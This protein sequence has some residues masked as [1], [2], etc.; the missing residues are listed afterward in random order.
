[1]ESTDAGPVLA[2][3]LKGIPNRHVIAPQ[4]KTSDGEVIST[5][6]QPVSL[7]TR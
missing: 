1:M 6:V 5:Q 4:R 3:S 2:R 7:Y